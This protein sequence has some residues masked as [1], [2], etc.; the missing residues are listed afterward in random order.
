LYSS[1]SA[2]ASLS[3]SVRELFSTVKVSIAVYCSL[4]LFSIS[5]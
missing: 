4:S 1:S 2:F 3:C 5:V